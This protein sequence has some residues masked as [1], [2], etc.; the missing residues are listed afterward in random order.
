L[1]E[2]E[3]IQ[4]LKTGSE[5]AFAALVE[6]CHKRVYNIVLNI[7]QD[8]TDAEDAAQETFIEVHASIRSFK[9]NASLYTW[10][11]RIAIHKAIDKLRKRKRRRRLQQLLPWWM[12]DERKSVATDFYHPG[13][14]LDNKEKAAALFK[15]VS[16]LPEKQRLAFTLCSIQK[17]SQAEAAAM[18]G[19]TTKSI[20]SLIGRAKENL[21]KL[22]QEYKK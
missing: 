19:Q 20:E 17:L 6:T 21:Q 11:Y 1:S 12:P 13:V 14:A 10:I 5:P 2:R 8:K 22:L 3:L 4:E 7:L 18:M 15:A 9:Q 16:A